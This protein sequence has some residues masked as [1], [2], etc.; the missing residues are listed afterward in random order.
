MDK[1]QKKKFIISYEGKEKEDLHSMNVED[2]APALLSLDKIF[3]NTNT[4]LN[5]HNSNNTYL[6]IITTQ[7]GSFEIVL[8][9]PQFLPETLLLLKQYNSKKLLEIVFGERGLFTLIKELSKSS[10]KSKPT[11]INNYNADT[12][13]IFQNSNIKKETKNFISPVKNQKKSSIKV[14]SENK[15]LMHSINEKEAKEMYDFLEQETE[16]ETEKD[17]IVYE[18]YYHIKKL[19]FE[20][21]KWT[22]SDSGATL[23]VSI[24]DSKFLQE[25]KTSLLRFSKD[26]ILKCRVREEQKEINGKL[27]SYYFIEKVLEHKP[28]VKQISF[29]S[30]KM[31]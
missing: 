4:L 5:G 7:E 15:D 21:E 10:V 14:F 1:S 23:N 27:K 31:E 26:D 24:E 22:L 12:I 13:N 28:A 6:K 18:K 9:L 8:F 2:L 3:Q 20:K 19:D 29:W 25:V 17:K 30:N 16:K 11:I